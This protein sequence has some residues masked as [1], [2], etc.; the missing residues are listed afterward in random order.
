MCNYFSEGYALSKIG[1]SLKIKQKI[2]VL[3]LRNQR[4]CFLGHL[5]DIVCKHPQTF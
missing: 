5:E 3:L 2:F 1:E 4:Y